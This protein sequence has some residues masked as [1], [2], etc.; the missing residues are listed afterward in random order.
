MFKD[1]TLLEQI[2]DN[3]APEKVFL[4][5]SYAK[6]RA[7]PKSDIDLCIVMDTNNKRQTTTELYYTIDHPLPIDFLLYTPSEWDECV[8]D[9]TS[10]AH[11]IN[12]EGVLLYA[13][14]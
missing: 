5:G 3:F 8:A 6:G 1:E 14:Q 2:K 11:K 10:F 7:T 13:R 9:T 12:S 4:F